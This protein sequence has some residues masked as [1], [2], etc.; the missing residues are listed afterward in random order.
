[1]LQNL[2]VMRCVLYTTLICVF[3]VLSF[4]V[5]AQDKMSRSEKKA[6]KKELKN[7]RKNPEIYQKKKIKQKE[8]VATLE[9]EVEKLNIELAEK[10]L[11]IAKLNDLVDELMNKLEVALDDD[12]P[13]GTVY[14]VQMGYFQHLNLE[15]F[16]GE[17]RYVRAEEID[18]AKRYTIGYFKS[19][20]DAMK[21]T[22]D[23][24]KLGIEDAFVSQYINGRRNMSF[25]ALKVRR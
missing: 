13:D 6:I 15:S 17:K 20:E 4:D 16:N 2:K 7:Y 10:E 11:Q 25:D 8:T 1:M 3:L 12:T 24:K 22:N 21:F 19:L 18:G 23:I 9:D 14:K 5:A